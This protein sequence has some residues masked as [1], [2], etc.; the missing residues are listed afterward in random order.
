MN[1]DKV[2]SVFYLTESK[3][4]DLI[5][6]QMK[7]EALI[8]SLMATARLNYNDTDIEFSLDGLRTLIKGMEPIRYVNKLQTLKE[9][10]DNVTTS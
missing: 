4:D 5:K 9:E 3:Y 2:T 1:E 10:K 6:T 8:N 7:Y